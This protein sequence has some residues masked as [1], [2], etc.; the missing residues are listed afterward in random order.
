[1]FYSIL[2][3]VGVRYFIFIV[4]RFSSCF[5]SSKTSKLNLHLKTLFTIKRSRYL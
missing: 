1:M 3:K 4:F 5:Y 2:I